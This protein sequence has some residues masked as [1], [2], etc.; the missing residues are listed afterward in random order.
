MH[1]NQWAETGVWDLSDLPVF[2]FLYFYFSGQ[3]LLVHLVCGNGVI[4]LSLGAVCHA[5]C[6]VLSVPQCALVCHSVPFGATQLSRCSPATF[7]PTPATPHNTVHLSHL[8]VKL[9]R[10]DFSLW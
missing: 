2:V 3:R 1:V 6:S 9:G 8:I 5:V 10:F 4:S 7:V